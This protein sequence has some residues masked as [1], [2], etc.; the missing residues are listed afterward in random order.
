M[1]EE[2]IDCLACGACC[3]A[4]SISTLKKP[5]GTA[6]TH[7]RDDGKCGDY[8]NRP[9]VCRAFQADEICILISTL[10]QEEKVRVIQAIYGIKNGEK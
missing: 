8:E 9:H 5:S 7:L 1:S 2:K 3:I 6:C 4:Y 10:T